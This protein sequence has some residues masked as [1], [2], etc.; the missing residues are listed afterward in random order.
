M[1]VVRLLVRLLND[2]GPL[3]FAIMATVVALY[4][5]G[6]MIHAARDYEIN[7]QRRRNLKHHEMNWQH[8]PPEDRPPFH[9]TTD[10]SH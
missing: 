2:Y 10:L 3:W 1:R 9:D 5:Y 7:E 4:Y 6:P 8:L